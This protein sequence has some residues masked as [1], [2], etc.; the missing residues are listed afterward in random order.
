MGMQ[1]I[2]DRIRVDECYKEDYDTVR[3]KDRYNEA[4]R[5][6]RLGTMNGRIQWNGDRNGNE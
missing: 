1:G 2:R 4:M 6:K 5:V 3:R